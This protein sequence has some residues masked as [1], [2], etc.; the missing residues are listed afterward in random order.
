MKTARG[1]IKPAD[2]PT[3]DKKNDEGG[4]ALHLNRVLAVKSPVHFAIMIVRPLLLLT[5]VVVVA[6]AAAA[7]ALGTKLRQARR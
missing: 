7:A 3:L 1:R 5:M 2:A 6:A 4:F